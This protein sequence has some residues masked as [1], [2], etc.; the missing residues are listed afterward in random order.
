MRQLGNLRLPGKETP[1]R[2]RIYRALHQAPRGKPLCEKSH[3]HAHGDALG[4][5]GCPNLVYAVYVAAD[6]YDGPRL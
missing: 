2:H 4:Q 1:G 6:A 5:V 3:V